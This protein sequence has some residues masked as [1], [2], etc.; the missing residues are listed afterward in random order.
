MQK[1]PSPQMI[2]QMID[3]KLPLPSTDDPLTRAAT[4]PGAICK[5]TTDPLRT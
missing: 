3:G 4:V 5:S 2:K 1:Y